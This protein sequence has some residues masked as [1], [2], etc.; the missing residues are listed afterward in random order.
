MNSLSKLLLAVLAAAVMLAALMLPVGMLVAKGTAIANRE[1]ETT[2]Q[3]LNDDNMP[4]KSVLVDSKGGAVTEFFD[5]NRTI[6]DTGDIS[7]YAKLALISIEDKRF[8]SH[9]GV[10]AQGAVRALV[11]NLA[12]GGTSQGAS[13]IEQ[14][15]IKNYNLYVNAQTEEEQAAAVDQNYGRKLTEMQAALELNKVYT[16]DE[17]LGKYLNLMFFGHGAYGI[18]AAAQ[19]YYGKPSKM[20]NIEESALLIG[21]LQAT[22]MYDPY[23][24]PDSAKEKRD[25]VIDAMVASQGIRPD[26]A[27]KAKAAPLGILKEPRRKSEGCMDAGSESFYCDYLVGYLASKGIT[28]EDLKTKGY[29]IKGT[30]DPVFQKQA[31]NSAVAQVDP[32]NPGIAGVVNFIKP[33]KKSHD[34]I[35]M[36]SSRTYGLNQ[37]AR[38]TQLPLTHS[39]VGHGAG[40]TFKVFTAAAAMQKGVG[41]NTKLPV[42]SRIEVPNM[43][44]GG[45]A[46]CPENLYCVENAGSYPKEMTLTQSLAQSPNT[47]FISLIE[48]AGVRPTVDLSIKLGLRSYAGGQDSVSADVIKRNAGAFTLGYTSVNP[49]EMANVGATLASGGMWCPPNPVESITDR[50]GNPVTLSA[51]KCEQAVEPGLAN[52]LLNGMKEDSISGTAAGTASAYGWKAPMAGKTGTTESNGSAA[53][54]G[55]TNRYAGFGY[56]FSDSKTPQKICTGPPAYECGESGNIYG[57][58]EPARMWFG[59]TQGAADR[60]GPLSLPGVDPKYVNGKGL[61]AVPDVIG[62]KVGEAKRVLASKGYKVRVTGSNTRNSVVTGYTPDNAY[63]GTVITLTAAKPKVTQPDSSRETTPPETNPEDNPEESAPTETEEPSSSPTTS[64]TE[65]P[66][67]SESGEPESE[68]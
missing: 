8:F 50:F 64:E 37:K 49:L 65:D 12:A 53:F 68:G 19:T 35:A 58:N 41:I 66:E 13:T 29:R 45:A 40:S 30:I 54:L 1:L 28:T 9:K 17:I 27:K 43:G 25:I 22:S 57:A 26:E 15:Y 34:I 51:D 32:R 6:V 4:T 10:D 62:M 33:G 63:R 59:T 21:M 7:Y 67:P 36:A 16:K 24:N 2:K 18:E 55:I 38:Q 5:Q 20:L 48:Y 61:P 11:K 56:V 31:H 14:Q 42:P 3:L 39:V 46:G 52:T 47:T 60:F 23:Q 44:T